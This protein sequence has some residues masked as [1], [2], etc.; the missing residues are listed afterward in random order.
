LRNPRKT[1]PYKTDNPAE[2]EVASMWQAVERTVLTNDISPTIFFS[3]AA[4]WH[5][6]QQDRSHRNDC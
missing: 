5:A 2:Q 4:W 1:I 3:H 6:A